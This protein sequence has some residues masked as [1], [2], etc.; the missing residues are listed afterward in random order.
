MRV[1]L[2]ILNILVVAIPGVLYTICAITRDLA[3]YFADR[4]EAI[5]IAINDF[6]ERLELR[7]GRNDD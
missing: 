1:L 7:L 4:L 5:A 3:G 6:F 2:A